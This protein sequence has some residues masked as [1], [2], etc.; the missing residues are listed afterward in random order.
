LASLLHENSL[1]AENLS[2]AEMWCI[3]IHWRLGKIFFYELET[4]LHRKDKKG[5]LRSPIKD[6]EFGYEEVFFRNKL[7]G[8]FVIVKINKGSFLARSCNRKMSYKEWAYKI[9]IKLVYDQS[10]STGKIYEPQ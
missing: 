1:Q 7:L 8:Q 9:N 2:L 3:Y 5:W 4:F 10:F 6:C